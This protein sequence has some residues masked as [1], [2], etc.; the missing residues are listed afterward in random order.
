MHG[1]SWS[2]SLEACAALTCWYSSAN[3]DLDCGSAHAYSR[4]AGS[5]YGS[6]AQ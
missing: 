6:S 3:T 4:D 5:P 2:S 1:G